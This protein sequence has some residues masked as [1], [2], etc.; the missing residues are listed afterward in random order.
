MKD[1]L[2]YKHCVP[3]TVSTVIHPMARR[4]PGSSPQPA[5]NNCAAPKMKPCEKLLRP[6]YHP[7]GRIAPDGRRSYVPR[8]AKAT[9]SLPVRLAAPV[10]K[11]ERT[12]AYEAPGIRLTADRVPM[13]QRNAKAMKEWKEI[14]HDAGFDW[15][16]NHHAAVVVNQQGQ[17]VADFEFEHS[18]EGWKSFGAKTTGL[19]NLAV[20]IETSQGAAVDQMLQRDY[21]VYP[22]NPA[23]A[24]SYR[25]RKVP[26][27]SK[28]D[29]IDAWPLADAL[30]V[31][32]H[33]WKVLQPAD[34]LSTQLRLLCRD[35][36]ALIAQRTLL[37]N[38]LQQARVEYYPAAREA[39]EDWVSPAPWDFVL[40]FPTPEALTQAGKR[41]WEKFLHTHR[42]WRPETVEQRRAVFSKADQFKAS[43]PVTQ[44]KSQLALSLCKLLRTLQQ[45]LDQYREQIE[46]LFKNHPDHDLFGS[47]PGA[48]KMLAPRLLAAIGSDPGRYGTFQVL[49]SF[50]GT[51]PISFESGKIHQAR[52][53]WNGDK[54]MRHTVHLWADCFHRVS[55][56]G[57]AYYR[58]K[59]QEGMTPACALRCLGQ[60][61]LKILFR[62]ICDKKPYDAELHARNQKKHGS[63]VLALIEK[64]AV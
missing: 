18:V 6:R 57:Q 35:E 37:V 14:T 15:A 41:R 28:T 26:S 51:A 55:P 56:W 47:L 61:L 54:F 20:A 60:R 8:L 5:V 16:R 30:R 13:P 10:P 9:R 63:G 29:H 1:L 32:G 12:T 49:Q 64:P 59:R 4:A 48:K 45:Q 7:A 40:E 50:A 19:A 3:D 17:I 27:G 44:A 22:V 43:A 52:I 34:E 2:R 23:A 38:P 36:G 25:Q 62:M 24:A 33:G 58:K 42:L 21:R 11:S 31:D 53:R 39:F 46:A